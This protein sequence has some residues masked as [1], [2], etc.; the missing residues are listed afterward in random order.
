MRSLVA[1]PAS[2]WE[3]LSPVGEKTSIEYVGTTSA[4]FFVVPSDSSTMAGDENQPVSVGR[5]HRNLGACT[6]ALPEPTLQA[7]VSSRLPSPTTVL[8]PP[9]PEHESP[10][11]ASK[12]EV[13]TI[14]KE[15]VCCFMV[16]G[17]ARLSPAAS[18]DATGLVR[19]AVSW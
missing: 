19:G 8:P 3:S 9:P 1:P 13:A 5:F 7:A 2:M 11:P 10:S 6:G 18:P 4:R 16:P 15:R 12:R 17:S 14:P